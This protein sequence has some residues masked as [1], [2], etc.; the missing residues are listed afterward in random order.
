MEVVEG[1]EA[2]AHDITITIN[3]KGE[4]NID[5][6]ALSEVLNS[7]SKSARV[8]FVRVGEHGVTVENQVLSINLGMLELSY[9]F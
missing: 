5:Q 4:I 8:T 2:P 7:N 3:A 9:P 6:T 1:G